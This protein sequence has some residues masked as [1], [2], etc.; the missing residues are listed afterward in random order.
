MKTVL[1]VCKKAL[2]FTGAIGAGQAYSAEDLLI[3]RQAFRPMV[4]ELSAS[5]VLY[6]AVDPN[7]DDVEEIPDYLYLPLATLLAIEI[8]PDFGSPFDASSREAIIKRIRFL[9]STS[10]YGSVQTADY[11]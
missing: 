3:P 7:D 9:G 5:R 2:S 1:D 11:F 8:G 6:L 4:D 10:G